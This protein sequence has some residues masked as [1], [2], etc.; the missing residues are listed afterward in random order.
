M[1]AISRSIAQR[2]QA[3]SPPEIDR[4]SGMQTVKSDQQWSALVDSVRE[5]IIDRAREGAFDIARDKWEPIVHEMADALVPPDPR[6]LIDEFGCVASAWRQNLDQFTPFAQHYPN[7]AHVNPDLDDHS[8]DAMVRRA[9]YLSYGDAVR[10][11]LVW[12]AADEDLGQ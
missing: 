9:L 6:I 4:H 8:M 1:P 3:L 12:A 5:T 7:W 2:L 10:N 11:L